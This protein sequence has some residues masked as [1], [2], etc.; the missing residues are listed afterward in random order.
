M[1]KY[2]TERKWDKLYDQYDEQ[3]CSRKL[4]N[5][6]REYTPENFMM[7]LNKT[8]DLDE[9]TIIGVKHQIEVVKSKIHDYKLRHLKLGK[10]RYD[11]KDED[12]SFHIEGISWDIHWQLNKYLAIII[13]DYLRFFVTEYSRYWD[14]AFTP[15]SEGKSETENDDEWKNNILA[16]AQE[17]D[18]LIRILECHRPLG[19]CN[20]DKQ[21][22]KSFKD[23]AY[24]YKDLGW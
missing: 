13:R 15:N 8:R 18:D 16:T 22:Q 4:E 9:Y 21:I 17:F 14:H 3:L 23:L 2:I 11:F 12:S 10:V 19:E 24:I 7:F 5:G 6:D 20:L 1:K